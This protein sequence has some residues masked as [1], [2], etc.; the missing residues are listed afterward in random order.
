M[1][2]NQF[3]ETRLP[4]IGLQRAAES[5]STWA[6][7]T[8]EAKEHLRVDHSD[9]D[10][11]ILALTKAA[12]LVCEHFC[13]FDFTPCEWK[14]QC[15]TW[16]QV[17]D[18][19]YSGINEISS[20]EYMDVSNS[21]VTVTSS[22]YYF[23][24]HIQP[25]SISFVD[26]YNYPSLYNGTGGIVVTFTTRFGLSSESTFNVICKQAVLMTI[27]DMYENRQSVIVGRIA[28]SIPKTV[29]YLLSTLKIQVL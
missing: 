10:T 20:I 14:F 25:N 15:D 13:N 19:P 23:K 8:S 17:Y 6:V 28:S 3:S 11:Y 22:D 21:V 7:S 12:Q 5:R 2:F 9:D 18:V 1:L 4:Q 24:P 16:S 26:G 29:E 27:A